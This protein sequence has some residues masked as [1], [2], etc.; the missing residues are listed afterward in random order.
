LRLDGPN[1]TRAQIVEL[2]SM[3]QV[4][5]ETDQPLKFENEDGQQHCLTPPKKR[6]MN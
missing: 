6:M 1:S 3:V 2:Q 5:D 4:F